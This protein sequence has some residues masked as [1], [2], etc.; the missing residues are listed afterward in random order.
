MNIINLLINFFPTQ[1]IRTIAVAGDNA[2]TAD[3]TMTE[4]DVLTTDR[5]AHCTMPSRPN[6]ASMGPTHWIPITDL[7]AP[8][9]AF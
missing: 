8:S 3:C 1:Y 6:R 2:S 7:S 5:R 9:N 4:D